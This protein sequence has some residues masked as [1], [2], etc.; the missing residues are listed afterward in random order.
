M[1]TTLPQ[2][3]SQTHATSIGIPSSKG[4]STPRLRTVSMESSAFLSPQRFK[5][6]RRAPAAEQPAVL[7]M[8]LRHPAGLPRP[9]NLHHLPSGLTTTSKTPLM[10]F[11]LCARPQIRP[12][13]CRTFLP[14]H[15]LPMQHDVGSHASTACGKGV[16]GS[17][18]S[19]C[20]GRSVQPRKTSS[21]PTPNQRRPP[22][23]PLPT[24]PTRIRTSSLSAPAT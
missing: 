20:P 6:G 23:R 12:I 1:Q 3:P 17:L 22:W 19:S 8:M 15:L 14:S 16:R 11:S 10:A 7:P 21:Q 13:A 24:L 5:S 4:E 2:P 18:N 9:Q